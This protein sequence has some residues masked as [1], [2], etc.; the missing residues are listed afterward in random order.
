MLGAGAAGL[1]GRAAAH[2]VAREADAAREVHPTGSAPACAARGR[3]VVEE[4]GC[5]GGSD[6][7]V[8][9]GN[10]GSGSR[11]RRVWWQGTCRWTA[12]RYTL[13][14]YGSVPG[15]QQRQARLCLEP[16]TG[17][18]GGWSLSRGIDMKS[19]GSW[20]WGFTPL[21]NLVLLIVQENNGP[22]TCDKGHISYHPQFIS[23]NSGSRVR[24]IGPCAS[25]LVLVTKPHGEYY[26][27]PQACPE[28]SEGSE[29]AGGFPLAQ[30]ITSLHT[31]PQHSRL[32]Q[33]V[34]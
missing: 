7:V 22:S 29:P 26:T 15:S 8:G 14:P 2:R 27:L 23:A 10:T 24:L 25:I 21:E 5:E 20:T 16:G 1:A 13:S 32:R 28:R 9:G 33:P 12:P 19:N 18:R 11:I 30:D 3:A 31:R 17:G 6:A 4:A 34:P